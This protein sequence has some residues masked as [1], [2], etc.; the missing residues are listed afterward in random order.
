MIHLDIMDGSFVPVIS[1]GSQMAK[2]VRTITDL[3]L[4]AHLMVNRPAS[5][6]DA[7]A[8]AGVDSIV[9]HIEAEIHAHRL[10]RTIQN[11]GMKAGISI[12]PSTPVSTIAEILNIVDQVLVMTVDPGFGGQKLII[13]TLEKVRLLA[14]M[15]EEG[16]G[17]YQIA[18]DGGFCQQTA[19]DVWAAGTDIAVMGSA[20]YASRKPLESLKK[21]RN[22]DFM[23]KV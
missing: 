10:I 20:F 16:E 22:T 17:N 14:Q 9:F 15:R 3:P 12:V 7:F 18:I 23:F 8:D 6:V 2:S 19:A 21:C 5:H 13:S 4:D 1:F 11:R